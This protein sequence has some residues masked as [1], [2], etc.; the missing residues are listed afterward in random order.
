MPKHS[1]EAKSKPA[2]LVLPSPIDHFGP[3]LRGGKVPTE[4]T[5]LVLSRAKTK[6]VL[7]HTLP[8]DDYRTC[9]RRPI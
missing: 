8:N 2:T 9:P 6:N 3:I 4:G 1:T 7:K 5:Y